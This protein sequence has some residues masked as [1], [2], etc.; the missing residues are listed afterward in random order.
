MKLSVSNLNS[1]YGPAH[2]LFDIGLEVGEGEVVA[3]LGR[4]GAGKSTT[5]RSIVGLV[6]LREG[7]ILFEGKDISTAPT[8]EIVRSGLGYVPEERRIFTDL[9]VEENLE[10]GR[11]KP[12]P[13]APQW[14]REKLY[15]LFPNLGEMKNRPGGRM[16][17][18][19]Q[20]MLTIA[21]TLMGNPS[22][23]LL[24]E[25]S[26]GLSP[27]IVEQMVDAILTMKKE[28]VSLVVSEQNLHFAKLISDRAY[29]IERGRI[30]FAG[31]MA[32]LDARPDIRDAHLS[33]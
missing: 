23:V 7:Q 5:F 30:C 11:Q 14:T 20:Q 25:P 10:V 6:A 8:H 2:I 4:N 1:H 17:G 24:D 18:G 29:I 28:G 31:T 26:E 16:S 33:I 13:G 22:L 9:T 27:K 15:K 32:E 3:L 19:E 21:R 12:R